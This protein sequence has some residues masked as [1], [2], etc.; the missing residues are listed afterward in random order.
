MHRTHSTAVANRLPAIIGLAMAMSIIG[1]TLALQ[2]WRA[3]D[4]RRGGPS[5]AP[6][7]AAPETGPLAQ[8]PAM[9]ASSQDQFVGRVGSRYRLKIH[10]MARDLAAERLARLTNARISGAHL[11][12]LAPP[13]DLD[14][15]GADPGEAWRRLLGNDVR[16][17]AVCDAAACNVRILSIDVEGGSVLVT[18]PQPAVPAG[19]AHSETPGLMNRPTDPDAIDESSLTE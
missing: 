3:P 14:W 19:L 1:A 5:T 17:S 13:L 7:K 10:G 8:P 6:A 2:G 4:E 16:Y 15:S 18:E 9:A 11:L 12:A